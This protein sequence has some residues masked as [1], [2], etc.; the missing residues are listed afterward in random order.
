L[1]ER[2][3]AMLDEYEENETMPTQPP[4]RREQL[5][6]PQRRDFEDPWATAAPA[7]RPASSFEDEPPF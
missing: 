4:P 1:K 2:W 5:A 3:N 6:S 7:R